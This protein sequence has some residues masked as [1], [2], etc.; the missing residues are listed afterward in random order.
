MDLID[1]FSRQLAL[2]QEGEASM[3][4]SHAECEDAVK[5]EYG[6]GNGFLLITIDKE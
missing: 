2:M 4:E 1:L 5:A 3:R 6:S